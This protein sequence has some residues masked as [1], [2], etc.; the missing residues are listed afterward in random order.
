MKLGQKRGWGVQ[1]YPYLT[2]HPLSGTPYPRSENALCRL[3]KWPRY[4]RGGPD[5][6]PGRAVPPR[7]AGRGDGLGQQGIPLGPTRPGSILHQARCHPS[8]TCA[9]GLVGIPRSA[10][11]DNAYYQTMTPG[12][13]GW[14]RG[15]RR[16]GLGRAFH[17][18]R[19]LGASSIR[20]GRAAGLGLRPGLWQPRSGQ[21]QVR[22]HP[23]QA[24]TFQRRSAAVEAPSR[25]APWPELEQ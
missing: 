16:P 5:T 10:R 1:R 12:P 9:V 21:P 15:S 18:G 3:G 13:G 4:W 6:D 20:S 8:A 7:G 25:Q 17:Q 14:D 22:Q 11:Y 19:R 24:P 2:P 23:E